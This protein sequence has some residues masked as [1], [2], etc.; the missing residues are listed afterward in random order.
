VSRAILGRDMP[1]I[2]TVK[3]SR[4]GVTDFSPP[5]SMRKPIKHNGN[6]TLSDRSSTGPGN[7]K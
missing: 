3:V 6:F 2:L 1:R 7:Y 4:S 5:F